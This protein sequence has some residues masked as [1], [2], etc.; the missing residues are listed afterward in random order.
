MDVIIE[1][2]LQGGA[3]QTVVLLTSLAAGQRLSC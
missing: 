3:G 1:E 2:L